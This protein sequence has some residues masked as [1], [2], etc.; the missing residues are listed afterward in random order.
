MWLYCN[1]LQLLSAADARAI[2]FHGAFPALNRKAMQSLSLDAILHRA[3]ALCE[4]AGIDPD[5]PGP[6]G[7]PEW[8]RFLGQARGSLRRDRQA[9]DPL[10]LL[11]AIDTGDSA[12][13]AVETRAPESVDP[14]EKLKAL[15]EAEMGDG[16]RASLQQNQHES[17][18]EP[19]DSGLR[20]DARTASRENTDPLAELKAL[21]AAQAA[22]RPEPPEEDDDPR[23]GLSE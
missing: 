1:Y 21:E 15:Y 6:D 17:S 8:F 18:P 16:A 23:F 19:T 22:W 12:P 3:R 5:Q 10:A 20:G 13:E 7:K 2:C 11:R 4:A 14:L 9:Q